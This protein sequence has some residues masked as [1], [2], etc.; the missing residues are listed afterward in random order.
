MKKPFEVIVMQDVREPE[1]KR[2]ALRSSPRQSV[3]SSAQIE[4]EMAGEGI[5][6]TQDEVNESVN[7]LRPETTLL[8]EE[9][10]KE[11][12]KNLEDG[13]TTDQ[14]HGFFMQS[15]NLSA[16]ESDTIHLVRQQ[17][18]ELQ[19]RYR[20]TQWQPGRTRIEKR[21]P[22]GTVV[23]KSE[24]ANKPK[25]VEQILRLT[26]NLS[27]HAEEQKVGELEMKLESWE[28]KYLFDLLQRP[29]QLVYQAWVDSPFLLR[30]CDVRPYR[31][32][33]YV[34]ISG[35]RQDAEEVARKL[36][37][38]LPEIDRLTVQL[39]TF[40]SMLGTPGW[41]N[42]FHKLFRKEDLDYVQK[43][44]ITVV[45]QP[46][47]RVLHIYGDNASHRWEARR[48][49][50]SLMEL[51]NCTSTALVRN[52]TGMREKAALLPEAVGT[53]VHLRH[54]KLDYYH[55]TLPT[56]RLD[57]YASASGKR[58]ADSISTSTH[59]E[60]VKQ[61]S[62]TKPANAIAV[63][64]QTA[65]RWDF[66]EAKTSAWSAQLCRILHAATDNRRLVSTRS[67]KSGQND[68][69]LKNTFTLTSPQTRHLE[70][71]LSYFIPRG[72]YGQDTALQRPQS[73]LIARFI[74]SPFKTLG[75]DALKRLPT[76]TL[77]YHR[78]TGPDGAPDI[79]FVGARAL[80]EEQDVRVPLPAEATD[81]SFA[82]WTRLRADARRLEHD[83]DIEAFTEGV[84]ESMRGSSEGNLVGK[85]YLKVRLPAAVVPDGAKLLERP[86]AWQK[87]EIPRTNNQKNEERDDVPV[88]YL[89]MGFEQVE[90]AE[91]VPLP[92]ERLPKGMSEDLKGVLGSLGQR[93]YL[94]VRE[95]FA[96]TMGGRRTEVSLHYIRR[97]PKMGEQAEADSVANTMG[98]GGLP[99]TSDVED[100][101]ASPEHVSPSPP[102]DEAAITSELVKTALGVARF[103]TKI[104]EGKVH[105]MQHRR[106]E[107]EHEQIRYASEEAAAADQESDGAHLEDAAASQA[108]NAGA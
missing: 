30:A 55:L 106:P 98:A 73:L 34:R 105:P 82:R 22:F 2:P 67:K 11:L 91:Y 51:P 85:P 56:G 43:R 1:E 70:T 95:V 18:N 16:I 10:Y 50:L 64:R 44:T 77:A 17:P 101:A 54:R 100:S 104:N 76:V 87:G 26:W 47:P 25:L 4:K 88:S 15:F 63:E 5:D 71:L 42:S 48:L 74:P 93:F 7:A 92:V 20:R 108:A 69:D 12:A 80:L 79:R 9:E 59:A 58:V 24:K 49:L 36:E 28:L 41:P 19:T 103:M 8:D 14:L 3:V 107:R 65:S 31:P 27:I 66:G 61:L 81:L 38:N 86:L 99:E 53:T 37:T 13:F 97:R 46:Q 57:A 39:D 68:I 52:A 102:S 94:K 6:P 21:L 84:R 33:N 83:G 62:N 29:E 40:S 60:I 75:L 90:Q 23:R 96:G 45:D 78:L 72:L 32:H 89:F 35:R